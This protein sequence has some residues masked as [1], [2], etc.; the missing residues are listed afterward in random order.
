MITCIEDVQVGHWLTFRSTYNGVFRR[1]FYLIQ[2]IEGTKYYCTTL[3]SNPAVS[4]TIIDDLFV[5]PDDEVF[6]SLADCEQAY[7]E[8]F[9]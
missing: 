8:E 3:N 2:S 9:I 5:C 7:P 4:D 1:K 6:E